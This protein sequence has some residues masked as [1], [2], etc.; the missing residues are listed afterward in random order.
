[1]ADFVYNGFWFS[2]EATYTRKCLEMSQENVSGTVTVQLFKGNGNVI[3][4]PFVGF[5]QKGYTVED[6]HYTIFFTYYSNGSIKAKFS[7]LVQQRAGF[8]GCGWRILTRR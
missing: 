3:I 2:P 5:S 6:D 7:Q 4:L 8:H 1:M